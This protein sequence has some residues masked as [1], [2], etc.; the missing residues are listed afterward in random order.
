MAMRKS[1]LFCSV[2]TIMLLSCSLFN[3]LLEATQ[4]MPTPTSML[5]L[6][7]PSLSP[8]LTQLLVSSFTPSET[9]QPPRK[10]PVLPPS[11]SPSATA[12]PTITPFPTILPL[13]CLPSQ[14][15]SE[16]GQ[17]KWVQNGN[18]ILVDIQGRL[19]IIH[20]LGI[21]SPDNLPNIQYMGPP[22]ATQNAALVQGQIVQLIPD[23]A[24]RD[25]NGQ[26]LRYVLI[27]NSQTFINFE[28]L[29]LGLAQTAPNSSSLACYDT[30]TQVQE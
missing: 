2:L 19:T 8:A 28:M 17:V 15:S 4:Q 25:Q 11:P 18:T 5:V 21:Q 14:A 6:P 1:G 29:R 7:N 12:S 16:F 22:A 30:F 26:F 9:I 10:T 20:Y 27:Y 23:G 3:S 13:T 24:P